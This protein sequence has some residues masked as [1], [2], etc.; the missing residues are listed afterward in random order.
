MGFRS[1]ATLP[2]AVIRRPEDFGAKRDGR[3][4]WD[5]AITNGQAVLTSATATFESTIAGKAIN[6]AGA[7]PGGAALSTTVLS[8]QSAT[9]ITLSTTSSATVTGKQ[10]LWGTDDTAAVNSALNDAYATCTGDG[11]NLC[12]LDATA[13]IYCLAAA[14]TKGGT[15]R[16][17]AQIPLP[18]R[19][20]TAGPKVT[21]IVRGPGDGAALLHWLQ[22][23]GQKSGAVFRSMLVGQTPDATWKSP[24]VIGGPTVTLAGGGEFSNIRLVL[25]NVTVSTPINPSVIG[26]DAR[27]C[28][29]FDPVNASAI[30]DGNPTQIANPSDSNG[31]GFYFPSLN[32][33]D[34]CTAG[35]LSV[36]GFYYSVG[37]S[38]HF[39]CQNL[40]TI[41]ANTALYVN[42]GGSASYVHG[43]HIG[44]W[45]AEA[46]STI[47]EKTNDAGN[48]MPF[49][50]DRLDTETLAGTA[51]KDPGSNLHGD[52]SYASNDG[53]DPS[54]TGCGNLRIVNVNR[55]RGRMASPPA[56]PLTTVATTPIFRDA[57][58]TV[59]GGT[60]TAINVDGGATGVTTGTV[61]VPSG[62]TVAWAGSV[63]PTWTWVLL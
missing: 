35:K 4:V 17:N 25:Q 2:T 30:A 63:A 57:A 7:G 27:R 28:A 20:P 42:T 44:Y 18:N 45:S 60:V 59:I 46:C 39:D 1:V 15:T 31:I 22:T 53:L 21:I 58:V 48:H 26:V 19:E 32:N 54:V 61:I 49:T 43:A 33:N 36:E 6:V 50:V 47:V 14:T 56:V 12:I 29:Q 16:G 10:A 34:S 23:V 55:P 8:R 13:G 9:Q 37:V 24:S 52:V 41:Y 3:D 38:D 5:A 40:T 62:K 11:T 51:I